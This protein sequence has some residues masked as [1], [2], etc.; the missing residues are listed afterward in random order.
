MAKFSLLSISWQVG[1]LEVL[2]RA[3]WAGVFSQAMPD[4][5]AQ[6]VCETRITH[7]LASLS[8]A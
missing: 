6:C 4:V 3:G 8:K 5:T 2:K 7:L 1:N